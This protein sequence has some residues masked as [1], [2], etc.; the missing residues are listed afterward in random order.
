[1]K[2]VDVVPGDVLELVEINNLSVPHVNEL[3]E[4]DFRTILAQSCFAKKVVKGDELAGFLLALEPGQPYGSPNYQWFAQRYDRFAYVDRIVVSE[5]SRGAG[6]GHRLYEALH[7]YCQQRHLPQITCEVNIKP[8][9]P[10]SAAFH[11]GW[12]FVSVGTQETEAGTKQVDLLV[13]KLKL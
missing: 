2:C 1:M 11:Q 8:E 5:S 9:N 13:K 10:G 7:D 4:A 6:V 3:S 12:G